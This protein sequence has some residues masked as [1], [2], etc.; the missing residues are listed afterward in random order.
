MP[1]PLPLPL[2]LPLPAP[3]LPPTARS[4]PYS[5]M[6]TAASAGTF[7]PSS[8]HRRPLV[9]QTSWVLLYPTQTLPLSIAPRCHRVLDPNWLFPIQWRILLSP[10]PGFPGPLF[11]SSFPLT[12]PLFLLLPSRRHSHWVHTCV[13]LPPTWRFSCLELGYKRHSFK[14]SVTAM[15]FPVGQELSPHLVFPVTPT[16][17]K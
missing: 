3:G 12:F 15:L 13:H 8:L 1:L 6:P 11:P 17:L 7:T 9:P 10:G 2:L 14:G 4:A 5:Q 16:Q